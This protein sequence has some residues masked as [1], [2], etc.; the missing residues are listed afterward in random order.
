MRKIVFQA[1]IDYKNAQKQLDKL[2]KEI[3][4]TQNA[5]NDQMDKRT[6]LEEQMERANA[7]VEKT[8][9]NLE[10]MK[11]ELE[12]QKGT[13][14]DT[15]ALEGRIDAKKLELREGVKEA[16]KLGREYLKADENVQQLTVDLERQQAAA[17]KIEQSMAKAYDPNRLKSAADSVQA[18][19][20]GGFKTILKY[21][22]GIRSI[23]ILFRRLRSVVTEGIKEL[24]KYDSATN[25]ALTNLKNGASN[26]KASFVSMFVPLL[27]TL[28]PVLTKL[29]NWFAKLI[30]YIGMFFAALR[31]QT[32][33]KKAI[34]EQAQYADALKETGEEAKKTTKYLSGLDEL[35]TYDSGKDESSKDEKTVDAGTITGTVDLKIPD[36]LTKI[37]GWIKDH[38]D[39]IL[40]VVGAIGAAFLGWKLGKALLEASNFLNVLAS[41]WQLVAGLIM[42]WGGL[43]LAIQGFWDAWQNGLNDTN[44]LEYLL[45]VALVVGGL[46]LAFTPVVAGIGAVVGA[47]ALFVLGLHDMI[48]A[49]EITDNGIKAITASLLILAAGLLLL[50]A[51]IAAIVAVV[52]AAVTAIVLI[53]VKNW[54]TIKDFLLKVWEIAKQ[55]AKNFWNKI[56]SFAEAIFGIWKALGT[57]IFRWLSNFWNNIKSKVTNIMDVLKMLVTGDFAGIKDKVLGQIETLKNGIKEKIEFIKGLFKGEWQLPHIKMPHFSWDWVDVGG[58]ISLP[59]IT[60]DWYAKGGIVDGATLIGAGEQGKEAIV[61]L[62]RNTEWVTKVANEI[63]DILT[64]RLSAIMRTYPMPAVASGSLI[65]PRIEVEIDGLDSIASK[66]DRMLDKMDRRTGGSY[67]F[68]AQIN[69]KTLFQEMIAEAKVQQASNGRNPFELR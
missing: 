53:I 31:G 27:Q 1:D 46:A 35:R 2:N 44:L 4:K 64:D 17:G 69:R 33:Y 48:E 57:A 14:V 3:E 13:G 50:G 8:R 52:V 23:Y 42:V 63:A 5:L 61:P 16:E 15:T 45:G 54:E 62:E 7:A 65:P 19:L 12:A 20:K 51:P 59:R 9:E 24:G 6:A 30:D 36:R 68:I 38:L 11:A 28:E 60:V 67:N 21:A 47:I 56:K 29:M 39:S 43:T 22:F 26:L 18:S 58:V 66:M 41:S 49:G 37:I 34:T 32:S 55:K 25:K 10:R 40:K